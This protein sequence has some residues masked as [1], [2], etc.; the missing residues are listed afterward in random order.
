MPEESRAEESASI[1]RIEENYHGKPAFRAR[2]D[3]E[4]CFRSRP[5]GRDKFD[6]Y[7]TFRSRLLLNGTLDGYRYAVAF[8]ARV[9]VAEHQKHWCQSRHEPSVRHPHGQLKHCRSTLYALIGPFSKS[10]NNKRCD[11]SCNTV[12]GSLQHPTK[13]RGPILTRL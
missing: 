2:F 7:T 11:T 3:G 10:V 8:S 4:R 5:S 9:R 1:K 12:A 6:P 13:A